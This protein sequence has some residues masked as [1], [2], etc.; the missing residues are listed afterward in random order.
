MEHHG[1]LIAGPK[2]GE[3]TA[4]SLL[5][6]TTAGSVLW[7]RVGGFVAW[8]D[9]FAPVLTNRELRTAIH[10]RYGMR[11]PRRS[12]EGLRRS[13]D[14]PMTRRARRRAYA[15]RGG[16]A[17]APASPAL[18]LVVRRVTTQ[19]TFCEVVRTTLPACS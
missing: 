15:E 19:R 13:Y 18:H 2:C 7:T 11:P 9:T 10:V 12:V 14:V 4:S 1:E 17:V 8:L 6:R 16:G 3:A 5:P